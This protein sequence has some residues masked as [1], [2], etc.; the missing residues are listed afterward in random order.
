[1]YSNQGKD[2]LSSLSSHL[3]RTLSKAVL[4]LR[5]PPLHTSGDLYLHTDHYFSM[6]FFFF[7]ELLFSIS[8]VPLIA[9]FFLSSPMFTSTASL[10]NLVIVN[11]RGHLNLFYV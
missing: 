7:F 11:Q 4:I 5:Y 1:M 10:T 2:L 6:D 3:L 9:L 8:S